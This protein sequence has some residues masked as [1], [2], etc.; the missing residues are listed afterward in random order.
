[1]LK[2]AETE[3]AFVMVRVHV[4]DEPEQLPDQFAKELPVLGVAESVTFVPL[5]KLAVQLEPQLIP[6]GLLVI[7]PPGV[8]ETVNG[9]VAGDGVGL[10]PELVF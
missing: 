7:V 6:G 9:K 5:L 4:G 8:E 3:I 2:L 1:M 10:G